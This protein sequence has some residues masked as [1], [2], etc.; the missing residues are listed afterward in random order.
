MKITYNRLFYL[1]MVIFLTGCIQESKSIACT[2]DARLCPDGS[3]VGRVSPDCKF[4]PCPENEVSETPT[5]DPIPKRNSFYC[6]KDSDCVDAVEYLPG[7][8]HYCIGDEC[9]DFGQRLCSVISKLS[10]NFEEREY[11][12][13]IW[14]A[15]CIKP[16]TIECKNNKCVA[17]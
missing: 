17:S 12:N 1:T 6:E 9:T 4:A 11:T 3:S 15:P 5:D 13:C 2:E 14:N 7:C 16:S 10:K 8:N